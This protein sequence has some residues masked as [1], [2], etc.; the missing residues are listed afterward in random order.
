MLRVAELEQ[1]AQGD[2]VSLSA[3]IPN[4][5]KHV[6]VLPVLGHPALAVG[7]DRVISRGPFQPLH[8]PFTGRVSGSCEMAPFPSASRTCHPIKMAMF[9]SPKGAER[10]FFECATF[11]PCVY[12]LLATGRISEAERETCSLKVVTHEFISIL[13][14][15][16]CC[17][18]ISVKRVHY[19]TVKHWC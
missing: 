9:M 6:S 17:A 18:L 8:R 5:S 11:F 19:H 4:P 3:D 13:L 7:L 15:S 2:G 1:V 10:L 14:I 12:N 16:L